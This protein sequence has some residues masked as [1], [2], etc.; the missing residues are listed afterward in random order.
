MRVTSLLFLS[1][2]LLMGADDAQLLKDV[3]YRSIGPYRA[4]RVT[5]VAGVATQASTY[6]FGSTGERRLLS[7]RLSGGHDGV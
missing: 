4:G 7:D 1:L 6:Y 5:A 2:V 3:K